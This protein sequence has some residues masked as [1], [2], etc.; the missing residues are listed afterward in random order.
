MKRKIVIVPGTPNDENRDYLPKAIK[1]S[2]MVV[3]ENGNNSQVYP[4]R[5]SEYRDVVVDGIEDTWYEYVPASYDGSKEVPLVVSMHGGLM[6]GWGQAV[7]TSWSLLAEREG[8]IVLFPDAGTRRFWI[9]EM[10]KDKL[11]EALAFKVDGHSIQLPPENPDDNHDMNMVLEL[12]DRAKRKYKIDAGRVFI[13]GMSMGNL[14]TSQMARYHGGVFAGKAGSG[15][16]SSP[17][18]LFDKND[19]IINRAGP[20]AVWQSRLEYDQVPPHFQ[21]DTDYVVKRNREYWKRINGCRDLPEIK[22]VGEDNLAFYKGEHADVVFRDVKNRDHGQTFDDAE[23]V[24]DYLF[25]GIRRGDNG[26]IVHSDPL[27]PRQGDAYAIAL[28]E[29]SDKAYVNNR[30]VTMN[31][32]AVKHQKLKYHGLNGDVI[33]RGEYFLVPITFVASIFDAAY[34]PGSEGLSAE[35][36][37]KDG[38]TLQFARGSIGCVVDNRVHSMYC[39]AVYMNG[40]LYV[41]IE[42]ICKRLFDNH[43]SVCED[44]LYITDHDAELS[45]NMAHIIRDEILA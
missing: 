42:W 44:V 11:E 43:A 15:G 17:G 30:L 39:E 33:V 10:E 45:L 31:G 12:I 16:P 6:S 24:W 25:S 4:A 26:E 13:Q 34:V 41:P 19:E 14:M 40:E 20:L 21:G 3:N 7:Y 22:I 9:V 38:R 23:L 18:V 32:P 8:F 36:V 29:G 2:D 1:G 28:A 35:L 27:C 5:L 37:W